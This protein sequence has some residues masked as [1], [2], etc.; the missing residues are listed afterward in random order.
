MYQLFIKRYFYNNT[1]CN[2]LNDG[3]FHPYLYH[4]N[5]NVPTF[6]NRQEALNYLSSTI[7]NDE[8]SKYKKNYFKSGLYILS[9]G[10][11]DRPDYQI[12]KIKLY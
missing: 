10:E 9:H 3:K 4:D 12:R 5:N 2:F 8:I 6:Q 7:L 11:F 1:L